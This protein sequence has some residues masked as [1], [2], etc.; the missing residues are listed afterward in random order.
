LKKEVWAAGDLYEPYVGRWSR[1]VAKEFL[2]WIGVPAGKQWLDVGCGTGALTQCILRDAASASVRAVDPSAGFIE[3]AK[4]HTADA[5]ASFQ[6][7]DAQALPVVS[8]QCDAAVAGLVLNFVPKP[9]RA[10]AEMR[11][12]VRPGGNVAAYV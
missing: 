6:G 1:V 7:G 2:A 11:R 8:G 9:E 12:A 10:A 5:R 4:A 3:Y